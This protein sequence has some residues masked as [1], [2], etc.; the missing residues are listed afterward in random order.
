VK[1]HRTPNSRDVPI[2]DGTPLTNVQPLDEALYDRDETGPMYAV[3]A[4]GADGTLHL[5]ADEI[6]GLDEEETDG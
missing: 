2:D 6:D 4:E 5:F 1:F 3:E